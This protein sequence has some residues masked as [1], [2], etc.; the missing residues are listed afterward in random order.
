MSQLQEKHLDTQEE[1]SMYFSVI[2]VK[3]KGLH[4]YIYIY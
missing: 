1:C 4:I 3:E 2:S